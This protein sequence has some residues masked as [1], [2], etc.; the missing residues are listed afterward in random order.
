VTDHRDR[1]GK[2]KGFSEKGVAFAFEMRTL[3][4]KWKVVQEEGMKLFRGGSEEQPAGKVF[5]GVGGLIEY[6]EPK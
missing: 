4:G 3:N 6:L 1:T 2:K 5:S